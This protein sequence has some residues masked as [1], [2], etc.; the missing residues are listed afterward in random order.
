[1]TNTCSEAG[2]GRPVHGRGLCAAHYKRLSEGRGTTGPIQTAEKLT[3]Q[4]HIACPSQLLHLAGQ[5]ADLDARAIVRIIWPH[6]LEAAL[7]G[8][9]PFTLTETR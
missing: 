8:L 2:C 9:D 4:P 3:D 5:A 1:M 7:A 6:L